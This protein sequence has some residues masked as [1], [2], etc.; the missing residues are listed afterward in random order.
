MYLLIIIIFVIAVYLYPTSGA[1]Y[2]IT[3][4]WDVNKYYYPKAVKFQ[5][6]PLVDKFFNMSVDEYITIYRQRYPQSNP[7]VLKKLLSL[8]TRYSLYAGGDLFPVYVNKQKRMMLLETNSAPAG[9]KSV[10]IGADLY[11]GYIKIIRDTFLPFIQHLDPKLGQIAVIYDTNEME[12]VAYAHIINK[13]TAERVYIY[14]YKSTDNAL[15]NI[16]NLLYL[17]DQETQT[18][19]PLRAIFKFV[20]VD[21]WDAMPVKTKTLIFNPIEFCIAGGRNKKIALTA[22]QV[23]NDL[24][25]PYHLEIFIPETKICSNYQTIIDLAKLYYYK[26]VIKIPYGNRGRGVYTISNQKEFD[27][28]LSETVDK[29]SSDY[30]VQTLV[31][32]KHLSTKPNLYHRG[33]EIDQNGQSYIFDVRMICATT[34]QGI[35]PV[36]FYCRR[37][38]YSYVDDDRKNQVQT[39]DL[40]GT[41]LSYQD[42]NGN[43][44][45]DHT[46][47][48][49]FSVEEFDQLN[50]TL[51]D[52]VEAYVQTVLAM[53]AIDYM[54]RYIFDSA[55]VSETLE[56]FDRYWIGKI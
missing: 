51:I 39:W 28:F 34:K 56:K 50:L 44:T 14:E 41:N 3:P 52:L 19:V 6:H 40:L 54:T 10:P 42:S 45:T 22:Y 49:T 36:T 37:A 16:N 31:G 9:H 7:I 26:L 29:D 2:I 38:K 20:T 48:L 25:K 32:P 24:L 46:R 55:N 35:R 11:G 12:C 8:Q 23:L 30:I 5:R 18:F 53:V 4:K 21:P 33:T 17:R 15:I 47:L 1:S 43:W 13:L 27:R